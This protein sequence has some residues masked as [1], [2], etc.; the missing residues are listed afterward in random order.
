MN[1]KIIFSAT[2][3]I[4][5]IVL[6]FEED[7]HVKI[8]FNLDKEKLIKWIFVNGTMPLPPYIMSQRDIKKEDELDYQTVY[9][10]THGSAAAPTAGLHF[11]ENLIEEIKSKGVNICTV[12]L[13]VGSGTFSPIKTNDILDHKIHSEWCCLGADQV[14]ILN[15]TKENKNKIVAVGTTSMRILETAVNMEGVFSEYIGETDIYIT[16]GFKF[17]AVDILVTNFHL[18]RSSLFVLV[19]A[20][21]G[22]QNMQKAYR[23]AIKNNYR[24]YSY[25]DACLIK[26]NYDI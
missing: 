25:G 6:A 20:F 23:Y 16:P 9:A 3:E 21:Y 24:F 15:Q 2:D 10:R 26:K 17:N 12:I 4:E 14:K 11:T 22:I 19:C 1:D 5:A 8:S 13:H 18:P 7:D